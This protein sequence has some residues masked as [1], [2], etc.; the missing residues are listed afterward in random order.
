[1]ISFLDV[2]PFPANYSL[3]FILV[4]CLPFFLIGGYLIH[5]YRDKNNN[6]C[7]KCRYGQMILVNSKKANKLIEE[8]SLEV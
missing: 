4:F 6:S 8:N 3:L 1:M 2:S 5:N 7:P